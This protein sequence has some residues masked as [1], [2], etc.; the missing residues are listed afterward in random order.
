[1]TKHR[2]G[3]RSGSRGR[4]GLKSR[5]EHPPQTTLE[6][7]PS[8][9]QAAAIRFIVN[10][11][12]GTGRNMPTRSP[13]DGAHAA[14]PHHQHVHLVASGVVHDALPHICSRVGHT[15][16][17]HHFISMVEWARWRGDPD[18]H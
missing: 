9:S 12:G 8:A 6:A 11:D 18:T 13:L 5:A 10:S 16:G 4:A 7:A 3:K 1:M 17:E 15:C 14:R 2:L